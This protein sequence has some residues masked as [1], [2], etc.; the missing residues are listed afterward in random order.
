MPSYEKAGASACSVLTDTNYFGG[1][2]D[3]VREAR[4]LVNMPLLRKEFIVDPYQIYQAKIAGADAI[5]LIAASIT[6]EEC[7]E[8]AELAH[9]LDLEVLLEIHNETE[10]HHL[11]K[12]V[13]IL[14][15]N[16]RNLETFHTDI[17]TSFQLFEKMKQ[18]AE[19]TGLNPLMISESG[20][21]DPAVVSQLRKAGFKGFLIGE[22]FMRQENPGE[23]L[24][25]F[26]KALQ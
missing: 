6:I 2:L 12:H 3:D 7:R 22:T 20:I 18:Q 25:Q 11:N 26:I 13:D 5:L 21:S 19:S 15:V 8:W 10:L 9:S 4:G 1:C 24:R 16:N 14:G 23:G 17:D